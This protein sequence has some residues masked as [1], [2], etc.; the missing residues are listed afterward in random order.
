MPH[1]TAWRFPLYAAV[2][3]VQIGELE[4]S[5]GEGAGVVYST[6]N[7]RLDGVHGFLDGSYEYSLHMGKCTLSGLELLNVITTLQR[8]FPGNGYDLIQRNC[9]HFSDALLKAVVG[10]GIPP[11]INRASRY[12]QWFR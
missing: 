10:K 3:G 5:F 11:Y 7:P 12:G 4:Y 9:N 8:A 2:S 6:H 1:N